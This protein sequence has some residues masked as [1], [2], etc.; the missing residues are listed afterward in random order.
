ML[1]PSGFS[2]RLPAALGVG[3]LVGVANLC[4]TEQKEPIRLQADLWLP[5]NGQPGEEKEGFAVE[6]AREIFQRTLG[7]EVDYSLAPW[8]RAIV[9]A[10]EGEIDG[11]IAASR[12][13]APDFVFPEEHLGPV[14]VVLLTRADST[15]KYTGVESLSQIRLGVISG[16][17]YG[18]DINAYLHEH[19][20]NRQK[21]DFSVGENAIE[22]NVLKL[23]QGSVDAI[24]ESEVVFQGQVKEL[25][26]EPEKFRMEAVL[27]TP[28][29]V[30]LAFS[31]QR[32]GSRALAA[33]WDRGMAELR[34]SGELEKILQ[35]Y[36]LRE[37]KRSLWDKEGTERIRAL[38][39]VQPRP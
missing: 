28:F 31:P 39:L 37:Q 10:R 26:F 25:G 17:D 20:H 27:G 8:L 1:F 35:R 7:R 18:P 3:F 36:N 23:C 21:V 33:A 16:Y 29:V 32:E 2:R 14:S 24:I 12:E 34:R 38:G 15:W 4:A 11:V 22:K 30:Y 19:R 13:E 6:L 5:Y 9:D